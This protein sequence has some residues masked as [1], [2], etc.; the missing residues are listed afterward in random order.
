MKTVILILVIILLFVLAQKPEQ[1]GRTMPPY[2]QMGSVK[3]GVVS[4]AG[5][6]AHSA[7][8]NINDFGFTLIR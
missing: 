4:E 3:V 1:P 2:W 5:L 7:I 6:L 8:E